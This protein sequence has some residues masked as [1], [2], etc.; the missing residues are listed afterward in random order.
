[1]QKKKLRIKSYVRRSGRMGPS[2]HDVLRRLSSEFVL[3]FSRNAIETCCLFSDTDKTIL[4]IGFGMGEAVIDAARNNPRT[5]FIAVDVHLPGISRVLQQIEKHEL[6]NIR[7][8]NHDSV[9][10]VENMIPDGSLDGVHVFFPDPWPKKKHHKRRLIKT[11]F[12]ETV[13]SKL[14]PGGYVY[15]CTDW[16]EYAWQILAVCESVDSIENVHE[17]FARA[18]EWRVMTNFEKKGIQAGRSIREIYFV[19]KIYSGN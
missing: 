1:M 7:L 9:E 18:K 19:K 15:I 8:I 16:E 5:G 13:A 10:V 4:E 2:K 6:G 12:M 11:V 14:R 17:R 3:P